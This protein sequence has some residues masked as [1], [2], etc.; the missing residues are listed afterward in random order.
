MK[1]Y[2][3]DAHQTKQVMAYLSQLSK[4]TMAC[5]VRLLPRVRTLRGQRLSLPFILVDEANREPYVARRSRLLN[6]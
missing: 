1:M 4:I 5:G 6:G 2:K 3:V